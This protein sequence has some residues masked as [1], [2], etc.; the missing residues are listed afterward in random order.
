MSKLIPDQ[1][2]AGILAPLGGLDRLRAAEKSAKEKKIGLWEGYGTLAGSK[3]VPSH[4]SNGGVP[5]TKG[6]SFDAVVV[7]IWGSDQISVVPKGDESGKERRL[8]FASVRGPRWV[9]SAV[10]VDTDTF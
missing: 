1:W 3:G 10:P 4:T 7:R 9:A 2:H 8:Q 6:S 5:T